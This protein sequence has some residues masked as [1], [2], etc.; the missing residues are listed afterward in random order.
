MFNY[1]VERFNL[2]SDDDVRMPSGL[3]CLDAGYVAWLAVQ[4]ISVVSTAI[5]E[6]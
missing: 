5:A 4:Y 2:R 1:N 6:S 3:L